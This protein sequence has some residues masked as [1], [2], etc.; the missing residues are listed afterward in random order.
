[1]RVSDTARALGFA[2]LLPQLAAVLSFLPGSPLPAIWGYTL[3][4]LYAAGILSFLGGIW[5]GFTMRRVERQGALAV[6]AVVPSLAG[7]AFAAWA[8]IMPSPWPLV[9]LGVAILATMRVD[10]ELVVT[11]EAP[12]GWW[13]LRAPLSLGLGGLTILAG[14]LF[15]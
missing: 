11:G 3:A 9:A 7:V 8:M 12:D 14:L 6:L 13:G 5:W 15:F 2:G 4:A 1:M 10:W